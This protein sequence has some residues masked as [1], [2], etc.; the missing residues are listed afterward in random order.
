M[1]A[2][3]KDALSDLKKNYRYHGARAIADRHG[4][5]IGQVHSRARTEGLSRSRS[6]ARRDN[7]IKER[8]RALQEH[9]TFLDLD[10]DGVRPEPRYNPKR[11]SDLMR[12]PRSEYRTC[13]Y[14]HDDASVCNRASVIVSGRTSS[15]CPYHHEICTSPVRPVRLVIAGEIID[16]TA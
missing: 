1:G 13:A 11:L 16:T 8:W 10:P 6:E 15:Y 3:T 14:I 12:M 7:L 4:L 2:W 9:K 5:T